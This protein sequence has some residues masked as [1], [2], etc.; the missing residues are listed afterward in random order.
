TEAATTAAAERMR[1]AELPEVVSS[2]DRDDSSSDALSSSADSGLLLLLLLLLL[3]W[4]GSWLSAEMLPSSLLS[5]TSLLAE[6]REEA[7]SELPLPGW[8]SLD[9]VESWPPSVGVLSLPL[10][11]G[12]GSPVGGCEAPLPSEEGLSVPE[13]SVGS[14]MSP[15]GFEGDGESDAGGCSDV[16]SSDAVGAS[17][18]GLSEALGSWPVATPSG[19]QLVPPPTEKRVDHDE[20]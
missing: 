18:V 6:V 15:P 10:S 17:D 16:G 4:E 3:A 19:Y 11:D 5:G 14:P 9:S 13:M 12:A 7:P 2:F 1:T 20:P 8:P